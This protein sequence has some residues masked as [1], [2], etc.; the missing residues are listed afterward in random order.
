MELRAYAF[1]APQFPNGGPN[2]NV[3]NS[4]DPASLYNAC[5]VAGYE[6]RTGRGAWSHSNFSLIDPS[7]PIPVALFESL[8]FAKAALEAVIVD[9]RPNFILIGAMS[10]CLRG[11]IECA[12]HLKRRLG[13]HVCIVLGG[14]HVNE[15]VFVGH[16]GSVCHHSSSPLRLMAEGHIGNV[17][18]VIVSGD[19]EFVVKRLGELVAK[20]IHQQKP[21]SA[22]VKHL[23]DLADTPGSWIVGTID[24]GK[25][26]TKIGATPMP[27]EL[28]I[29]C[30]IFGVRSRFSCFDGAPTA[31]VFSD[32]G[33]GCI[34]NC[35][36]CSE[37]ID[38]VGAPRR[39]STSADRLVDQLDGARRVI[40]KSYDGQ[41]G[42]AFVEDSTL[43][44]M[45]R[46]LISRFVGILSDRQ[47]PS[48]FG[49]QATIDQ[50]LLNP[51]A[52]RSLV[53]VGLCYLFVGL[54][55]SIPEKVPG[56]HK[57]RS[58]SAPWL[59]RARDAI[60]LL[61]NLGIKVG[62]SLLFGLGELKS[63]REQLFQSLA[64]WR[65]CF[66]SPEIISMNWAVQHP[67]KGKDGGANYQYIDWLADETELNI[68]Q[69]FGEASTRYPMRGCPPPTY[70]ELSD[71]VSA[72]EGLELPHS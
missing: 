57:R 21:A 22:I 60:E 46:R 72:L 13:D 69:S 62:V 61:D 1:S 17:F 6:A 41:T 38:I 5:R 48:V 64:E 33:Q 25:I 67:L 68:I 36:F 51:E 54:E 31:H 27:A 2:P 18:D 55:T 59:H 28:P 11:A 53:S 66:A 16:N 23:D 10:V 8:T 63:D 35:A 52:L 39:F 20:V 43:L 14:R 70:G 45:N 37:A 24:D 19:G 65:H 4:K 29:P 15:S 32:V 40:S 58:G 42:A 56:F 44:G 7:R 9:I 49:G 34:Y 47:E 3:L 30:E 12:A 71:V 50:I 26:V